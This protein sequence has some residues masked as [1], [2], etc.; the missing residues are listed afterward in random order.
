M[1]QE[2]GRIL[3]AL[4]LLVARALG[5]AYHG[6]VYLVRRA[7]LTRAQTAAAVPRGGRLLDIAALSVAADIFVLVEWWRRDTGPVAVP[8]IIGL[9]AGVLGAVGIAVY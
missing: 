9:V 3:A 7:R 5:R 1:L 6:L 4:V 8:A 2:L